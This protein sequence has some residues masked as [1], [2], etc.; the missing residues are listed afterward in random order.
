[1]EGL[2][3]QSVPIRMD[4]GTDGRADERTDR[5]TTT[6]GR[7]PG[8]TDGRTQ[9]DG[10]D[11]M[12]RTERTQTIYIYI[13]TRIL[14]PPKAGHGNQRKTLIFLTHLR[15]ICMLFLFFESFEEFKMYFR[16]FGMFW[17]IY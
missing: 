15:N 14:C 2:A 17:I 7:T 1:M 11:G 4:D 6:M 9:D 16:A 8:R 3:P 10:S 5:T 12:D 13:Y